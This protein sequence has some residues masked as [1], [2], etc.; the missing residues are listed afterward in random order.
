MV[1]AS[2]KE[3][4]FMETENSKQ[5]NS[6]STNNGWDHP[7]GRNGKHIHRDERQIQKWETEIAEFEQRLAEIRARPYP[8]CKRD[9]L[10]LKRKIRDRQLQFGNRGEEHWRV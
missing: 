4:L 5:N 1:P 10:D 9:K 6:Q 3:V 2:F 7:S 8:N